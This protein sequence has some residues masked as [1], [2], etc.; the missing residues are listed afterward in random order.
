MV[1]PP[2]S[3]RS[4]VSE[5]RKVDNPFEA[6][7]ATVPRGKSVKRKDSQT[8]ADSFGMSTT[9]KPAYPPARQQTP[10]RPPSIFGEICREER[11][12]QDLTL[13]DLAE[14]TGLA[15]SALS[16]IE[17]NRRNLN[18]AHAVRVAAGLGLSLDAIGTVYRLSF[19]DEDPLKLH[20]TAARAV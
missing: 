1:R 7:R 5:S 10:Y 12:K 11:K 2:S 16:S 13:D 4:K 18:F 8:S 15:Q 20:E 14:R 17:N 6:S 9:T 3:R 19:G